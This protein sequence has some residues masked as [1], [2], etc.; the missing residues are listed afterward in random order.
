M[1]R[2][3]A[4]SKR[5]MWYLLFIIRQCYL[6]LNWT[7]PT[8]IQKC[9]LVRHWTTLYLWD[10]AV[11]QTL[12]DTFPHCTF[13]AELNTNRHPTI[14]WGTHIASKPLSPHHYL[15]LLLPTVPSSARDSLVRSVCGGERGPVNSLCRVAVWCWY[16]L[17][18]LWRMDKHP[19]C[20]W[21]SL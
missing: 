3:Y 18:E 7:N 11:P 9:F 19:T 12:A 21:L 20:V 14:S 15:H 5:P 6:T 13:N 10:W 1:N 2:R 16:R 17:L 4:T 8:L